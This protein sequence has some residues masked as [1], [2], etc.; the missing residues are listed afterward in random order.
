MK[1]R[2]K[3]ELMNFIKTDREKILE[4]YKILMNQE[5][6]LKTDIEK[7]I[8]ILKKLEDQGED[9]HELLKDENQ[10]FQE[11]LVQYLRENNMSLEEFMEE[12]EKQSKRM[13][14]IKSQYE[15]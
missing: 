1:S 12:M 9:I 8:D 5:V 6:D 14:A 11:K 2:C 13:E 10:R 3:E 4:M 7:A 15:Y